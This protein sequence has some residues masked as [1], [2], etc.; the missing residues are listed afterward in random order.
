MQDAVC[1]MT[2]GDE[3]VFSSPCSFLYKPD[4]QNN[5]VR[6]R[7][8]MDLIAPHIFMG[9]LIRRDHGEDEYVMH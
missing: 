5:S 9:G 4:Y 8:A 3:R 7:H 2:F 6:A 1:L